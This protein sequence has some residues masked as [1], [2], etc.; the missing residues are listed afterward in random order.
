MAYL[1]DSLHVTSELHERFL[2]FLIA[3]IPND[4][5]HREKKCVMFSKFDY[6]RLLVTLQQ[7]DEPAS[8]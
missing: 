1:I 4:F 8:I 7:Y 2:L 5:F 6:Q 3:R